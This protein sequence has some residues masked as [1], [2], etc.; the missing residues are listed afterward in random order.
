[1]ANLTV[2]VVSKTTGVP[3]RGMKVALRLLRY[4]V[5]Y[6]TVTDENGMADFLMVEA[7]LAEF[8]VVG[9]LKSEIEVRADS[10]VKMF[11]GTPIVVGI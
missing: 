7:G 5:D 6:D 8:Y 3:V 1:M 2:Q 11:G 9:V 10:N 4:G